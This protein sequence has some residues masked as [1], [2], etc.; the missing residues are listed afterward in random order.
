MKFEKLKNGQKFKFR[1][2]HFSS[3]QSEVIGMC[4]KSFTCGYIQFQNGSKIVHETTKD[5]IIQI[6]SMKHPSENGFEVKFEPKPQH[7]LGKYR[8]NE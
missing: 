3:G 5:R 1:P 8:Y 6:L 7:F 2:P 4:V